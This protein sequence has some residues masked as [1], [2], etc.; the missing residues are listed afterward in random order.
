MKRKFIGKNGRQIVTE[1]RDL[2]STRPWLSAHR[3]AAH[4]G[5]RIDGAEQAQRAPA[6]TPLAQDRRGKPRND[7]LA[8]L[9]TWEDEGGSTSAPAKAVGSR[10]PA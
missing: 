6:V 8:A 4:H 2:W 9:N 3:I 5:Y 1:L 7:Q 10:E